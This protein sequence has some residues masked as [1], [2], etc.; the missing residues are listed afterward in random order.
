MPLDK[1]LDRK[2]GRVLGINLIDLL[3]LL[4]V[5]FAVVSYVSKPDEPVYRGNQMYIAIQDVQR[6]DSRGFLVKAEV[7]GT[8]LWD[9]SP[10]KKE[11]ILLPS[12][13]GRLR[14]RSADGAITVIGGERAYIEDVAASSI[15][16]QPADNYLVVFN[17]VPASFENNDELLAFFENKKQEIGANNLYLDIEIAVDSNVL[18]SE[19]EMVVNQINS[20]YLVRD[21][22]LAR[23]DSQGFV[24]NIAKGELEE[25]KKLK[26]GDGRVSTNHIRA[27]AGYIERPEIQ[28]KE[29]YHLVSAKEI[30]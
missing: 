6:L 14:L 19:R 8:Y 22:Y 16:L 18:P 15:K 11:G 24:I 1:L 10:F 13:S 2:R 7:E 9:N 27:Y 21:R 20:M 3:V 26:L 17:I 28:I 5:L 23:S 30:L 12:S 29:D 25:L 4:I